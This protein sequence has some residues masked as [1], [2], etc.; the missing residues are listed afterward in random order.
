M[1]LENF[2][3]K[4]QMIMEDERISKW[5][6]ESVSQLREKEEVNFRFSNWET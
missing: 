6:D 1:K 2:C 3:K 4:K 5:L